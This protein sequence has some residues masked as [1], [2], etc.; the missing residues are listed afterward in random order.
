MSEPSKA[1]APDRNLRAPKLILPPGATDCH[2]HIY[3]PQKRFPLAP[4]RGHQMEDSTLDDLL[5][6]QKA[7]GLSHGV[8]TQSFQNGFMYEFMLHALTSAPERLRG[9]TSPAPD[10]TD[11]EL[12]I[13]TKAGVVGMRFARRATPELD[14]R[15]LQRGVEHGWHPQYF[16]TDANDSAAWSDSILA[17]KGRFVLDNLGNPSSEKGVRQRGVPLRAPM[18]RHRPV[19]GQAHRALLATGEFPVRRHPALHPP[20]RG[21]LSGSDFMGQRLAA[22]R[23]FQADAE[24]YRSRRSGLDLGSRRGAAPQ[25]VRRQSGRALRLSVSSLKE[26]MR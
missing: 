5:A 1:P 26:R 22:S 7:L 23:L 18:P 20:R 11:G 21:A 3:G 2:F 9:V 19:L 12:E 8:V 10:I 24:R 25:A 14:L 15:T 4:N 16:L 6:L 13:L 17:Q